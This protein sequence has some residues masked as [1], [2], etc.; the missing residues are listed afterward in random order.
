MRGVDIIVKKRQGGELTRE[1]ISFFIQGF[2]SGE[3]ADYQASA[4]AMAVYFQG[5]TPQEATYL[6]EA[7]VASGEQLDL[8]S[9]VPF[10]V[11]K[12]STGGVGDKT[13]LVV[14][15]AV[16][17]CGVPVGKMSGRGLGHTGGT[18]DKMESIAGF[19]IDLTTQ[20]FLE[21]LASIGAVLGGQ[22][23]DLAPADKALY[24]LRDVTGT[25]PSM[26]LIASS[27]MSKKIAAGA[28]AVVLDVK[29]GAG[30]FMKTLEEAQGLARLMV[31]IGRRAGLGMMALV[32]DMNQPLGNA[33]GNALEVREAIQTMQ[34]DGPQDFRQHCIEVAGHMLLLADAVK[35]LKA[36]VDRIAK[37]LTD[38]SALA[39]FRAMVEAQGGDVAM[40]DDPDKLPR[41]K[42]I[43]SVSAPQDGFIKRIGAHEIG[44]SVMS[45]GGGRERK[46]D[47][48]DYAVGI[49]IHRKVG[50]HV[51]KGDALFTLHA[52]DR[53]SL[54]SAS[55]RVLAAHEIVKDTV[56][57][58]PL[59]YDTI[60]G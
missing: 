6:T 18:L 38:G 25:V 59:F 48:I 50:D 23:A 46:G 8:S 16:A 24:A 57:P 53:K 7:M 10:A 11:D 13:T 47:T 56:S 45:L 19:N 4:W 58:L 39:K 9:V 17:A 14:L 30:A 51:K 55:E 54:Q 42:Y 20:A 41:A 44:K 3:I 2:V 5:M 22:T 31:E 36:G 12:H 15:P 35:D 27:V 52:S 26:P 1:E 29:I 37:S 60:G 43:E 40:V 33:V 32:S 49:E 34:G 28:N 21:Q